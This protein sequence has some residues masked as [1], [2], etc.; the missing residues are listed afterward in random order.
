M[1]ESDKR[2]ILLIC[3]IFTPVESYGI[4][5]TGEC[6]K[7][8]INDRFFRR[9]CIFTAFFTEDDYQH[10]ITSIPVKRNDANG[11]RYMTLKTID[12]IHSTSFSP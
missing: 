4:H 7:T 3:L 12:R 2:S 1:T 6:Q 10:R 11:K 9:S 8:K 5:A